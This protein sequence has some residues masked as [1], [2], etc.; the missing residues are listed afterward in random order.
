MS[1]TDLMNELHESNQKLVAAT[2]WNEELL[3]VIKEFSSENTTDVRELAK[4]LDENNHRV[5]GT[6]AERI[7]SLLTTF[8]RLTRLARA[9]LAK[10]GDDI[11]GTMEVHLALK[12]AGLL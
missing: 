7:M 11:D 5:T 6:E 10:S 3:A 8:A 12:G 1:A 9:T 2:A 4:K